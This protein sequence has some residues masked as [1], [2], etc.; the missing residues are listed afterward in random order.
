MEQLRVTLLSIGDAVLTTNAEGRVGFLNPVAESLTGWSAQ[1]AAGRPVEEVLH[2][3]TEETRERTE[4][5][6]RR[7][8]ET[9]QVGWLPVS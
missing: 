3:L 6:I 1:E 9:D 8:L 2:L 5:P 4:Y 7:V